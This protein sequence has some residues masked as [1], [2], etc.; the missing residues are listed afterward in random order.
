MNIKIRWTIARDVASAFFLLVSIAM[1][2]PTPSSTT[3]R[4]D[5]NIVYISIQI[6]FFVLSRGLLRGSNYWCLTLLELL[7]F[8]SITWLFYSSVAML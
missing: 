7:G 5:V 6:F 4:Q 1:F 8:G 3:D 2:I